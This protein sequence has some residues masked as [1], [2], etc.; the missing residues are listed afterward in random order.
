M[1]GNIGYNAGLS[2]PLCHTMAA[3]DN[4]TVAIYGGYQWISDG[5][6]RYLLNYNNKITM[7]LTAQTKSCH[8][9]LDKLH[10][11]AECPGSEAVTTWSPTKHSALTDIL[12]HLCSTVA[13]VVRSQHTTKPIQPDKNISYNSF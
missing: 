6:L 3:S 10:M 2:V 13:P 4:H 9:Q 8:K 12:W 5:A 1:F 7:S 11:R